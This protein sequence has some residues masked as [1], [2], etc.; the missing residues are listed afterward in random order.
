MLTAAVRDLHLCYPGQ[1]LTDVRTSCPDLWLNNPHI[2]PM[3]EEE[4]GVEAL[5]CSYPL[6]NRCNTTPHHC[7][8]GFIEFLNHHL[9]LKITPTVFRGDIHLSEQEKAWYSQVHELTRREIPFWIIAAGGKYDV[10]IKWWDSRRYQ[11][12]VDHFRGPDPVRAGGRS[13]A[14]SP[15]TGGG[16]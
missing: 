13:R 5:D 15:A 14:S 16:Y 2:T 7:L 3:K 9:G 10:T 4:P 6:I 12:V 8:H 11:E 1:F